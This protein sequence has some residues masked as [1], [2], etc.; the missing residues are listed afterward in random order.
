MPL[1]PVELAVRTDEL[2]HRHRLRRCGVHVD[3]YG[4]LHTDDGQVALTKL[5]QALL[6]PLLAGIGQPVSRAEVE[7]ASACAGGPTRSGDLRRALARL[8][9]RLIVVGLGL[10]LLSGRALLLEPSVQ[11]DSSQRG[12]RS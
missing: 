5:Q 1:D 6:G 8:R 7:R 3:D 9:A 11:R 10:H 12:D 4:V 2:R